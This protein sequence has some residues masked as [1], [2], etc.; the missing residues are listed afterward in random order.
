MNEEI[1]EN[2]EKEE[3]KID[4]EPEVESEMA[5]ENADQV[6]SEKFQNQSDFEFKKD[7]DLS[8]AKSEFIESSRLNEAGILKVKS[9]LKSPKNSKEVTKEQ[10]NKSKPASAKNIAAPTKKDSAKKSTKVDKKP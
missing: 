8:E 2:M 3:Y 5:S 10:P 7:E 4:D 6:I 9:N 1:G